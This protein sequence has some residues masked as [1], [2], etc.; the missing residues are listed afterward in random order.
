MPTTTKAQVTKKPNTT[1]RLQKTVE[2][3]TNVVASL[4]HDVRKI[5]TRLVIWASKIKRK[6]AINNMKNY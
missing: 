4:E 6:W 3:L 5:K 1:I 2:D